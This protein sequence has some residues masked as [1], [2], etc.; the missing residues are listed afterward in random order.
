MKLNLEEIEK[1][2][3]ERGLISLH[4]VLH[5]SQF[6]Y[7]KAKAKIPD[8]ILLIDVKGLRKTFPIQFITLKDFEELKTD[9]RFTDRPKTKRKFVGRPFNF[10]K[11]C[12]HEFDCS[13]AIPCDKRSDRQKVRNSALLVRNDDRFWQNGKPKKGLILCKSS[14]Y[15]ARHRNQA[16]ICQ[17]ENCRFFDGKNCTLNLY[18]D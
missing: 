10:C 9:L 4:S 3:R 7:K 8:K 14:R 1:I 6:L 18:K 17:K 5:Q 2:E 16:G 12:E 15:L 13:S 11:G